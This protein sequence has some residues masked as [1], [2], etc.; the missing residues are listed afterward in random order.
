MAKKKAMGCFFFS[1]ITNAKWNQKLK[2]CKMVWLF[3]PFT[4]LLS[5]HSKQPCLRGGVCF[6]NCYSMERSMR[7][8]RKLIK[9][10]TILPLRMGKVK[11]SV[12]ISLSSLSVCLCVILPSILFR[13]LTCI[14]NSLFIVLNINK[15]HYKWKG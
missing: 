2:C 7:L 9:A 1:Y 6:E 12:S 13:S 8:E 3:I 11:W 5:T 10:L 14:C 15:I 4:C